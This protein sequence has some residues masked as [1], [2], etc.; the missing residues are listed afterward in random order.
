MNS[1]YLQIDIKK[2]EDHLSIKNQ[3]KVT[4]PIMLCQSCIQ[5]LLQL[6]DRLDHIGER[7]KTGDV[8]QRQIELSLKIHRHVSQK[9]PNT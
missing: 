2:G 5:N 4:S 7:I 1:F 6:I 8:H 3:R 9:G